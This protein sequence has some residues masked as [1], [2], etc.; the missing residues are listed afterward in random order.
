MHLFRIG[1]IPL[2]LHWTFLALLAYLGWEGWTAAGWLGAT[3]LV[4]FVLAAFTCVVLHELGHALMAKRFGVSTAR[5]VLMPIGGMAA[6]DRIPRRPRQEIAIALAG[7]AVNVGLVLLAF[8]LGVRFPADWDPL[9]FPITTAEFLRHLTAV[10][11]VMGGFNLVPVF[12]MDGGRVFRALLSLRWDYLT[13]TRWAVGVAKGL[14][15]V[16]IALLAVLPTEPHWMGMALFA[17]IIVAGELELRNLRRQI[18]D[19]AR[20]RDSIA[21]LYRDAGVPPPL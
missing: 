1:G 5:I 10:N 11:I 16:A 7:P 21:R 4:G 17:F 18:E 9:L 3:W 14:G 2:S 13:A 20:W 6:F 15:L 19:E 8:V 12:P